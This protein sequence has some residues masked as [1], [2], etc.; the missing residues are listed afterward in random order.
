MV[1]WANLTFTFQRSMAAGN[2][3]HVRDAQ[4][5]DKFKLVGPWSSYLLRSTQEKGTTLI[6]LAVKL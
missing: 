6:I 4:V 2:R 3:A 5:Q 1:K